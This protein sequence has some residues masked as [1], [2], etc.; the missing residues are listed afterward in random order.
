MKKVENILHKYVCQ[1]SCIIQILQDIQVEFNYLPKEVLEYVSQ[2]LKMPMSKIYSIATFY[3]GFSL[4]PRGKHLCT[5]CMGTACHVRGAAMILNEFERRLNIKSG[6]TTED[7]SYTLE[8]VNCLGC[9]AI[10]PIIVYD[11]KYTG[12]F[13]LKDVAS[14]LK[15]K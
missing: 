12:E 5:V 6:E 4:N 7:M 13:K 11:G 10:G 8:T 9:C 3:A 1:R 2:R 14:L 15:E